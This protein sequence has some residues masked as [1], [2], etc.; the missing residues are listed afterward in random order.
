MVVRT[1]SF[2]LGEEINEADCEDSDRIAELIMRDLDNRGLVV[3]YRPELDQ[4]KAAVD[5]ELP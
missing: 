4:R 5:V 1:I 2:R 3:V